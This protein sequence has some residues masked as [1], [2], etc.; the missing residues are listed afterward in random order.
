MEFSEVHIH[1]AKSLPLAELSPE[2]ILGVGGTLTQGPLYLVCHSGTRAVKAAEKLANLGL[3]STLVVEGGIQAWIE[4]GYPVLRSPVKVIS[5]ERQ[6]RI[7]AGALVLTGV[8]LGTWLHPGFFGLAGFVGGGLVFAGITDFCG[9]GLLLAK[10][11]YNQR[12][13]QVAPTER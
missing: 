12:K 11:P 13:A 4:A 6:V 2:A 10:L 7:A 9:M 1:Q 5:L 8:L 3:T